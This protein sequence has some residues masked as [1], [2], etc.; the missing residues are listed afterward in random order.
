MSGNSQVI[1]SVQELNI[2]GAATLAIL[3]DA[4]GH[5]RGGSSTSVGN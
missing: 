4:Y 3:S 1:K 5:M 2:S